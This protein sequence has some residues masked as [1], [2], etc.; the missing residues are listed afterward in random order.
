[1]DAILGDYAFHLLKAVVIVIHANLFSL[2]LIHDSSVCNVAY[3]SRSCHCRQYNNRVSC[4]QCKHVMQTLLQLCLYQCQQCS[5]YLNQ[6]NVCKC[7]HHV[8]SSFA[9]CAIMLLYCA[10]AKRFLPWS[11]VTIASRIPLYLSLS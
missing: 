10:F 8:I 6:V 11:P 4:L 2:S 3:L 7:S 5:H 9:W 1:M